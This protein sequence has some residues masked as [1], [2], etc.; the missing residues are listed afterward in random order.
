M[1]ET[2]ASSCSAGAPAPR[3]SLISSLIWAGVE[4]CAQ[5][6]PEGR[7]PRGGIGG[8]YV[9]HGKFGFPCMAPLGLL[10]R[11]GMDFPAKCHLPARSPPLGWFSSS[12]PVLAGG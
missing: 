7:V 1:R 2:Q 12:L 8:D 10:S 4:T 3:Q 5:M 11:L 6:Q 9:S